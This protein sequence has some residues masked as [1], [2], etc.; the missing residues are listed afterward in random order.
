ME[1]HLKYRPKSLK[2][3]IG[4]EEAVTTLKAMFLKRKVPR[5][6]LLSG[7][8]GCGKTTISRILAKHLECSE[9]DFKEI[10][11]SDNNGI[12][13]IRTIKDRV[14]LRPLK[15]K[16]KIYYL[17][18]VHRLTGEAQDAALKTLEEPPSFVYFIL[19]TTEPQ[20]LKETIRTR[21]TQ[22]VLKAL[23]PS[24]A[25]SLVNRVCEKE[26][27]VVSD[28]V[29]ERIVNLAD[30]SARKAL[31]LLGQI[32]A[33]ED[34]EARLNCLQNSADQIDAVE[35]CK[36]LCNPRVRWSDVA[37][38]LKGIKVQDYEYEGI[39]R[40][41][42]SWFTTVLLN[43]GKLAKRA[44]AVL[45]YFQDTWLTGCG[46]AGLTLACYKVIQSD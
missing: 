39:R 21:C 33:I 42:L 38:V 34:D 3:M 16:A 40:L 2:T 43:G 32:S 15:G 17:D 4:Q 13:T 19:A 8:S 31:V 29:K 26:G 22:V 18:E 46:K 44:E 1:L 5:C 37:K 12:D 27:L 23:S 45:D 11:C 14:S 30:G 7:P 20:K 9:L 6:I 41:V 36:A 35:L 25:L 10:N 24:S 28:E